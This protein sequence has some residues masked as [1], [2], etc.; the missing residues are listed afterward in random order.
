MVLQSQTVM[1]PMA[2][3]G[4]IL[5]F[6]PSRFCCI[7]IFFLLQQ[8]YDVATVAH[9]FCYDVSD[10][11]LRRCPALLCKALFLRCY[12]STFFLLQ[13]FCDFATL[14][15][16]FCYNISGELSGEVS[17]DVSGEVSFVL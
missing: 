3:T 4:L 6:C 11:S 9:S 13:L 2:E 7:S 10:E 8:L 14:V 1:V 5:L 17:G 15:S 12:I 16:S